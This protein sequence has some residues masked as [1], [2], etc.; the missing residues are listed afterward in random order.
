MSI[1]NLC[2]NFLKN[3]NETN[4]LNLIRFLRT[5]NNFQI[6]MIIGNLVSSLYPYCYG[7]LQE[8][9]L[10]CYYGK[11]YQRSYDINEKILEMKGID[12]EKAT[13]TLFNQHFSINHIDNDFIYYNEEIVKSIL[14]R[15]SKEFPQI[16]LTITTCKRFD[17]FEKT[18]NSFLNCCLDLDMID[19]WFLI[20]DNSSTSDREKMKKLY[21][22]FTFYLKT[23]EEKGHIKSMNIIKDTVLNKFKTPFMLHMED[24]W[25]FFA[26]RHYIREALDVLGDND[27]IGQCLFNKNYT[28]IE[29]DIKV[30]GGDFKQTIN[31]FRYYIHEHADNQEK[32]DKWIKKHGNDPSSYYWP[33]FSFRPSVLRTKIFKDIGDFNLHASHFEMEYAYRYISLGYISAFFEGFYCIHTGRLTSQRHDD[34]IINAYKLNEEDQF[35][36]KEKKKISL[37]DFDIKIKTYILNL[38]RRPDRYEKFKENI[39]DGLDFLK[40]ERFS[41]VDGSL[42]KSSN[43]LQRIFNN[44][45]YNMKVGMVGCLMSHVKMY[46]ELIHCDY[47]AFC[48]LEDDIEITPNFDRKFLHLYKELKHQDSEWDLIYLGHHIRN[49]NMKETEYNKENMPEIEKCDVFKSF[50][51]S[52]GGTTGYIISKLGAQKLL[53]FISETGSTNCIDTLQQKAA[54]RINLYYC[55]PHLIYSDCFR[56]DIDQKVDTD[57]QNAYTS[58]TIPFEEKVQEEINFYLNLGSIIP[59]ELDYENCLIKIN[60]DSEYIVY[61]YNTLENIEKLKVKTIEKNVKFYTI[62]NKIIFIINLKQNIRRYFHSFKINDKY[63]IEDCNC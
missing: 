15:K 60:E 49:I 28:E 31:N 6:G 43:Q 1:D 44:N 7:I 41:A 46:I 50:K 51:R 52:L 39:K 24:D 4:A 16:T 40:Y 29:S 33:H 63:S 61:S 58:L 11:E 23:Y 53:D 42:L 56:H 2:F 20:D 18:I 8:Y 35:I 27:K 36:K 3:K 57:I 34:S 22:F 47:D 48:I 12:E 26:K 38:D 55:T 14:N 30:K 9:S 17:L 21:P 32:I 59:E 45:D 5:S 37:E 10:C 54:N 19:Y 62:E 25:K 13:F